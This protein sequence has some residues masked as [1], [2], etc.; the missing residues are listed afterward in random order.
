MPKKLIPFFLSLFTPWFAHSAEPTEVEALDAPAPTEFI[1]VTRS[2]TNTKLQTAVTRYTRGDTTV[3]LIGAVHIGD[4]NY[5]TT[6]NEKF[7]AYPALLFE[8]IGGENL[9]AGNAIPQNGEKPNGALGM[10]NT[11]FQKMQTALDLKGQKDLV[12]YS[13]ENFIHADLTIEEFHKLNQEKKQSLGSFMLKQA[14]AKPSGKEPSSMGLIMALIA[15]DPNKLKL[16]LV[17]TLGEGD[18]QMAA[19]TGDNVIIN[20]RNL[21]CLAVMQD[22]IKEGTQKIGIFY[23]AAHFP[24][25]EKRLIEMGF[26]Q[27]QQTWLDAWVIPNK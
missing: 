24:D 15:R 20:D 23:G 26:K 2:D 3:D 17:D 25:M 6:L 9:G 5:Y 18:A 8:M 13:P 14:F 10:L 19:M 7:K 1:R 4:A 22:Q 27:S 16:Q 11:A 12:D 21:K